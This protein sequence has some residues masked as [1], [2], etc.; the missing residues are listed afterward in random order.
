MAQRGRKKKKTPAVK[1]GHELAVIVA[2]V[3]GL[4]A[5]AA[6]YTDAVGI[7]GHWFRAACGG[8][9]GRAAYLFPLLFIGVVAHILIKKLDKPN[10]K[11]YLM[12]VLLLLASAVCE[13][14][15]Y[16]ANDLGFDLWTFW[17]NGSE[18]TGGGVIGGTVYFALHSFLGIFGAALVLSAAFIAVFM[19]LTE[20]SLFELFA[21][22]GRF[23]SKVWNKPLKETERPKKEKKR[24][25]QED[26]DE[27]VT[28]ADKM[29]AE[30]Q[31]IEEIEVPDIALFH[32]KEDVGV[33]D[34]QLKLPVDGEETEEKMDNDDDDEFVPAASVEQIEYLI[35]PITLLEENS[36]SKHDEAFVRELKETAKKLVETL[37]SFNVSAKV[38]NI[39]SGPSVTR[40]E[41]VAASGT[42]VSKIVGLSEDIALHLAVSGIRIAPVPGKSAVGI[43][44]PN[45]IR[46]AVHIRECIESS[47]FVSS[48]SKIAFALGKDIT[49]KSTIADIAKMPHLL[50]A[51]ATGSGKSVCINTIITS[52]LYKA[53]PNEVKLL[54]VDPKVVE[55]GVYNGI[56]HLVSPVVT[57]PKKAANALNWAVSEMTRRYKL[58]ADSNVRDINGYNEMARESE[59]EVPLEQIVIII[60]ELADLMMV[61]PNEVEDAI[62][63]LA[64]MARAAG[65]HLVIA[66][67]RPSVDVIT[68]IIKANIPSRISFAVSSQIDSRTILD[69]A[70]AEKLL[71]RG[72]MLYYPI[73]APKPI[74]IQGAF[75]NDKEVEAVVKF[76]KDNS[77]PAVY[78]EDAIEF[79]KKETD[80]KG[81]GASDEEEEDEL[82]PLLPKAIEIVIENQQASTSMLQRRMRVGYARAAR[83]VD[84]LE[85]QG[86][87]GP[88]E[89][90]KPREVLLTRQQYLEMVAAREDMKAPAVE[91]Q[92]DTL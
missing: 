63:R 58:F 27:L 44:V 15:E 89:G 11:H 56:P 85:E 75:I 14:I 50:I 71:G 48:P 5:C 24:E 20:V 52:L 21:G 3:F 8:I 78:N 57:D 51:G 41:I 33:I 18:M 47:E 84:Q 59:I 42:K 23:F 54:M 69:M 25:P 13:M 4:L 62:C 79:I 36:E 92:E 64:Q 7:A 6:L 32:D 12:A 39:H 43:E 10:Y 26:F 81:K 35:P 73:G 28:K 90:S 65:M 80:T 2:V 91:P 77:S 31:E 70:G 67:Q 34:A 17:L 88:F 87:V 53:S 38:V 1:F 61:A 82:D 76:V 30:E 37:K 40:Y 45:Q 86:I 46:S 74:R 29:E 55:L 60:D 68:G 83:L 9:F 19:I 16:G 72:D 66:T 22:I 49:G